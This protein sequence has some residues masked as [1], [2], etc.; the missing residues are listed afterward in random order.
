SSDGAD[1]FYGLLVWSALRIP[2]L[3]PQLALES[4]GPLPFVY[5]PKPYA[6]RAKGIVRSH[7]LLTEGDQLTLV[8]A[9]TYDM[10][11][12]PPDERAW[13]PGETVYEGGTDDALDEV[14]EV[15]PPPPPPPSDDWA[16]GGQ[17]W[18][19]QASLDGASIDGNTLRLRPRF[20]LFTPSRFE[21]DAESSIYREELGARD[22]IELDRDV[23]W[24]T[25]STMHAAIRFAQ[26]Q[27]V[28]FRIGIGPRLMTTPDAAF[29]GWD[30]SYGFE[31]F[32]FRPVILAG[33][34]SMGT[35]GQAFVTELRGS[36]GFV[37][38]AVEIMV[39]G[40]RLQI[41]DTVLAGPTAGVRV[42][43]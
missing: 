30:L 16:T 40:E 36:V 3:I 11:D 13:M 18:A 42:W 37:V 41:G 25:V 7:K 20:R 35:V 5:E 14:I 2:I 23:D 9:D 21:L 17:S 28:Q 33:S 8:A 19:A 6:R 29:M 1:T 22:R 39:G 31:A 4:R 15:A 12:G 24:M 34:A 32:P 27:A 26:S 43:F 38:S 10:S